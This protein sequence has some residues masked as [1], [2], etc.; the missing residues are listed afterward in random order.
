MENAL[1]TQVQAITGPVL[2]NGIKGIHEAFADYMLINPGCTLK[3]MSGVFKYSVAWICTVINSDLFKAYFAGRR[4]GVNAAVAGDLPSKLAA[5]AHMATERIMEVLEKTEDADTI[6]DS[7]DKIL[8]RFG[9]APNAKGGAQGG[10]VTN[11]TQNVFY[12]SKE[13]HAHARASFAAAHAQVALPA[14][15]EESEVPAPAP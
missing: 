9:Y 10:P 12:L 5:A 14:P 6:I 13:D 1:Q 11:N 4:E 15:K 7:F 8:H 3:E 2:K